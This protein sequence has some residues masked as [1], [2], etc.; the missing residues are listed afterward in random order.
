[1]NMKSQVLKQALC[2]ARPVVAFTNQRPW[3]NRIYFYSSRSQSPF[4]PTILWH[5]YEMLSD[6]YD[7][8]FCDAGGFFLSVPWTLKVKICFSICEVNTYVFDIFP[9][10]QAFLFFRIF[11]TI[12]FLHSSY[13]KLHMFHRMH[14]VRHYD[15]S[16]ILSSKSVSVFAFRLR[17]AQAFYI[18]KNLPI[19]FSFKEFH[20]Y[21]F[22]NRKVSDATCFIKTLPYA[23]NEVLKWSYRM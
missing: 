21:F 12:C 23:T 13:G 20:I 1:M 4:S 11:K 10:F 17:T 8:R 3:K 19:V 2:S 5:V 9:I 18:S 6:Y 7:L 14:Y 15:G 22:C 16:K